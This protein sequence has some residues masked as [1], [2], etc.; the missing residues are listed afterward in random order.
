MEVGIDGALGVIERRG[1]F[2]PAEH[3]IVDE[4]R[5]LRAENARLRNV[6][7]D[8]RRSD[9]FQA[10]KAAMQGLLSAGTTQFLTGSQIREAAI[11]Q[12]DALLA[13]LDKE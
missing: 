8:E 10:A 9:R 3:A 7:A 4:V 2:D 12:A 13:E 1:Y 5:R 6:I 11:K